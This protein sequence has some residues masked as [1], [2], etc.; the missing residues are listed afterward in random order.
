MKAMILAAGRGER[1]RPLT[2]NTPKPLLEVAGKPL[3]VYHIE[4][5]VA[6][7]ITDIV[8]N[9]SYRGEQIVDALG[10]GNQFGANIE[11][12]AES[13]PLE[14][15][16]GILKA[17]PLLGDQPF[18]ICNGD[19]WTDYPFSRLLECKVDLAYLVVVANPQHRTQG[20]FFLQSSGEV[21][22]KSA[23]ESKPPNT[24]KSATYTG[25]SVLH[26]KLFVGCT[27]ESFAL[28]EPLFEAM[29]TCRVHGEFYGGT[30]VDV[31]TPQRLQLLEKKSI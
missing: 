10:N 26:P 5:L 2:D 8:I 15:G 4:S 1:M 30:W 22:L 24:A 17:L 23:G 7:G 29:V 19:I 20:D 18:I 25:I 16:G 14:T 3:I 13:E 28:R 9:H 31:G 12:S 21:S 11:Y 6:A 27:K